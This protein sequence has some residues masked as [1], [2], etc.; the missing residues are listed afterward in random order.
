[1][2]ISFV[3]PAHNEAKS[4]GNCLSSILRELKRGRYHA[5][6]IVVDNASTDDTAEIAM[7]YPGVMVV[8]ER[9]KGLVHARQ[10]GFAASTGDLVAHVDADTMLTPGWLETVR[11]EFGRD[12]K[13][14]CLSGPFIYYD[15]TPRARR[16]TRMFYRIA[17]CIYLMNRFVLR[18]SSMVQ[19]GNFV[20]R[21]RALQ[22]IGGFDTRISFYGEDTDI[23]KRLIKVGKVKWTFRLPIYTSG[24]RLAAEGVLTTGARYA[25][26]YFWVSL[27]GRPRTRTYQDIRRT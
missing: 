16:L 1:M 25:I 12:P 19:G 20:V 14:V 4:I 18:I 9:T 7:R 8:R 10:A 21:R 17:F 26:N 5:E 13:L 3:I 22:A 2:R 23:A 27:F 11:K 6:I 24:R 15:L